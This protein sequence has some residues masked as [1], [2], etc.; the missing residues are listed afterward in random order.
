MD[1]K[2]YEE[3]LEQLHKALDESPE[4]VTWEI[5][6]ELRKFKPVRLD[7]DCL[8]AKKAWLESG[9][10]NAFFQAMEGKASWE[11]VYPGMMRALDAY[12]K[13][14]EQKKRDSLRRITLCRKQLPQGDLSMYEELLQACE[15]FLEDKEWGFASSMRR[16][17]FTEEYVAYVIHKNTLQKRGF[18][19]PLMGDQWIYN[20]TNMGEV[21]EATMEATTSFVLIENERNQILMRLLC[22]DLCILEKQVFYL[23]SPLSCDGDGIDIAN[24]VEI[25][26]ENAEQR[27]GVWYIT[28]VEMVFSN[29]V[30]V[31]NREYLLEVINSKYNGNNALCVLADGYLIDDLSLRKL[32]QKKLFRRTLRRGWDQR[33]AFSRYGDYVS[34]ISELYQEDC[35]KLINAKAEKKFSVVIP[36]RNSAYTLRYT[37]QT[38]LEQS[39]TGEYEIIVSDNSTDGNTAVQDLCKELNSSKIVYLRTPRNLPLPK[40]F[41]YAY[42]HATGEYIFAL[43]SDDGLLPW[44]L[45]VLDVVI[46]GYPNEEVI[47]W[48]RGFYAWPGF[49]GGQQNQF[50]IPGTYQN[51]S[52]SFY[53]KKSEEYL[54]AVLEDKGAM[55]KLPMLYINSCFKRSYFST[56]LQKTGQLWNGVCQDIYIGVVTAAINPEILNIKY[57]LTIAGMSV[58]SIG[59]TSNAALIT[60]KELVQQT[61]DRKRDDNAGGFCSSYLEQLLPPFHT[62]TGSL[63]SCIVRCISMGILPEEYLNRILPWKKMFIV[64]AEEIN[65]QDVT[66]DRKLHEMQHAAELHGPEFLAWFNKTIYEPALEPKFFNEE[67]KVSLIKKNYKN[68]RYNNGGLMLDASEVGVQD[69]CGA[70]KLFQEI[71]NLQKI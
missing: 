65:V 17:L 13:V 4:K 41:E 10:S 56:L 31:D 71:I 27:D 15:A 3:I 32:S 28:P 42:L 9:D 50:I 44:A 11:F 52:F 67:P 18:E 33:I 46:S 35:Y 39:Y 58:G 16:M 55:Y 61:L 63:Y 40:S 49:N 38:C 64:M 14:Y 66:F 20:L 21:L 22:Q 57:P 23:T 43:G 53:Y 69:I 54:A 59:A 12:E 26:L 2:R 60:N 29:G 25:S 30:R 62:D 6:D 45:E 47:Q 36:A 5:I 70:V 8:A 1:R 68:V 37:L 7:L 19:I 48:D 24:T 51:G 34:I